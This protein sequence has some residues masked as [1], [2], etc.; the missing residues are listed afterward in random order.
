MRNPLTFLLVLL[1]S[2]CVMH[3]QAPDHPTLPLGSRAPD[4]SLPGVDGRT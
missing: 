4:F 3:A 1:L 2:V